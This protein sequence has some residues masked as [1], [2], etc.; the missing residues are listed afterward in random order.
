MST[1][2]SRM[3]GVFRIVAKGD[4]VELHRAPDRRFEHHRAGFSR[5]LHFFE[6]FEY[7]LGRRGG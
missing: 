1:L 7:P 6:K 5:F 4:V 2:K 3:M